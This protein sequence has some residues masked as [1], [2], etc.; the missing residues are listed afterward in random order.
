[1]PRDK[2]DKENK[3]VI[4]LGDTPATGEVWEDGKYKRLSLKDQKLLPALKPFE[5]YHFAEY[6]LRY[7]AF[8]KDEIPIY[9]GLSGKNPHRVPDS[10]WAEVLAGIQ[11]EF[12]K[13]GDLYVVKRPGGIEKPAYMREKPTWEATAAT[14]PYEEGDYESEVVKMYCQR[15]GKEVPSP[16]SFRT[17]E[18]MRNFMI[19]GLCQVCQDDDRKAETAKQEGRPFT[20]GDIKEKYER[21][22]KAMADWYKKYRRDMT[23]PEFM[24]IVRSFFPTDE[25][26]MG[27]LE[28]QETP[29][30]IEM[31]KKWMRLASLSLDNFPQF[32]KTIRKPAV[33]PTKP[34]PPDPREETEF[35]PDSAE[36]LAYTIDDIGYRDKIDEAFT[37]AIARAKSS[38]A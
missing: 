20:R 5:P 25:E 26:A 23:H 3:R 9:S 36:F 11:G 21:C 27:Y 6:V 34:S 38:K 4:A 30:G 19:T 32:L 33:I 18:D 16:S 12:A 8:S 2:F 10:I 31:R 28:W 1:M 17:P 35:V 22:V 14:V 24:E 29:E 37:M 13:Q 7:N 15:C